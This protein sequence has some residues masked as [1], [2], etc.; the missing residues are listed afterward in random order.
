[1]T[2]EAQQLRSVIAQAKSGNADAFGRLQAA[3]G[4]RLYGYFVRATG[5]H[6]DAEDLLG[7]LML[8]LVRML[9]K[10]DEQGRFDPWLFRIAANLVRD[11]IRRRKAAPETLSISVEDDDGKSLSE[12]IAG[13]HVAV[14]TGLLASENKRQLQQELEKLDQ[15]TRE[16]VLMRFYGQMSFKD[17]A[18]EFDCPLGT[19]LAKVHRGLSLLRERLGSDH[20]VE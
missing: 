12:R 8:R 16:M 9:P 18:K 10:Y 1:M 11:R 15:T 17:L 7:E 4:G 20:D 2:M 3:Y 13:E 6:H 19:A 5:N 14:D